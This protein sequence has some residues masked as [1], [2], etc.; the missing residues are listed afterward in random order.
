MMNET[1]VPA[2]GN[3]PLM[4][5]AVAALNGRA[6]DRLRKVLTTYALSSMAISISKGWY[7]RVKAQMIYTISV[8]GD[9]EVY[10]DL[11][12]WLIANMPHH[13][14]RAMTLRSVRPSNN[15][16]SYD[17]VPVD[18][19]YRSNASSDGEAVQMFYDGSK[20]QT[21]E[22]GGY[23][24]RVSVERPD[25]ASRLNLN[26][27]EDRGWAAMARREEKIIF[28][29]SGTEARDAVIAFIDSLS[30]KRHATKHEPRFFMAQRWGDWGRRDE[31]PKRRLDSVVLR[32][33]QSEDLVS[34]LTKF[35][36]DEEAYGRLGVPW[37]RGY[38]LAGPPGTGKTS[39][40]KALAT[41]F[42]LDIYYVPL[43]DLNED[44]SLL[45]LVANVKPRSI[46]LLEDVDIVPAAL[47]REGEAKKDQPPVRFGISMAGLLNAL[48]G[49]TTP[50]GL[51]TVMTTNKPD[52]L[53]EAL[54]R[55]GRVDRRFDVDHLDDEQLIRLLDAFLGIDTRNLFP[56]LGPF[57]K[58]PPSDVIEVIKANLG[59]TEA[60]LDGIK[61][62]IVETR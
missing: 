7:H 23:S 14:R 24:V 56:A 54:T 35:L 40:A 29:T 3:N 45:G 48:D 6:S 34:D 10:S 28:T 38:L 4:Q 13:K 51:I 21:V 16:V 53:D 31:V 60:T 18:S 33:G 5:Y 44:A 57:Q 50:H 25:W 39:I 47:D 58:M 42:G 12:S 46:L 27:N 36:A 30:R 41:Y 11:H 37:H 61:R 15:E 62:L 17:P 26:S 49:V 59:D 43:G 2:S 55:A 8:P 1:P 32:E 22:I 19:N 9:D 20:E 52:R